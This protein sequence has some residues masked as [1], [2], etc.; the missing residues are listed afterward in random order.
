MSRFFI[1]AL[2]DPRTG[3]VHYV[4]ETTR[5]MRRVRE[6]SQASALKS[7]NNPELRTWIKSLPARDGL[8]PYDYRI[9]QTFRS[10][11]AMWQPVDGLFVEERWIQHMRL[12]GEPLTNRARGGPVP[13]VPNHLH[14]HGVKHSRIMLRVA[15]RGP[16]HRARC[17]RTAVRGARHSATMRR[18]AAR[19]IKHPWAK[20]D[21]AK[22][23]E[24][25][26]LHKNGWSMRMLGRS[27]GVGHK[28]ISALLARRTWSHVA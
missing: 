18:V 2:L 19:G 3:R 11:A 5:G 23:V 8:L 17:K 6:H 27:F 13:Q 10:S 14:S 12:V 28:T 21:D 4:G 22:V 25:R 16:A 1:Y 7:C 9:L 20:L 24:I 15:A 26:A